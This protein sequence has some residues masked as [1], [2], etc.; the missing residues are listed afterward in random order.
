[1]NDFTLGYLGLS[2]ASWRTPEIEALAQS[3]LASLKTLPATVIHGGGLATTEE[4]AIARCRDFTRRGVD[5]V[6]LHFATF[7]LGAMIP[8]AAQRLHVPIVLFANP[9]EPGPGGAWSQNSFC[10]ANMAAYVLRNLGKPYHFAWGRA[11]RA[12]EA[13]R[14][15]VELRRCLAGLAETRLGWVG[16]RVPGFYTSSFDELKLRAAFGVAVESID[17]LEL[18][19]LA[20]TL[21]EAEAAEGLAGVRAGAAGTREVGEADLRLAASL[22]QAFRRLA[23]RYRLDGFAVRCWPELSDLYGI[24][25]CSV[26]GLLN[27]AGFVASCEGDVRG[28]VLMAILKRLGGATPFF[29]DLISFDESANAGVVWHCGAAPPSLCRRF[30]ETVLRLHG[31]VDGGDKKGVT[32]DFSLK[33]GRVTLAQLDETPSGYRMLIAPGTALD[34]EPFLRGNPL[35]IAF[36]GRVNTL[37]EA[38]MKRGLAHHYAVVHADLK[39]AL[40][41]VCE[42]KGIEPMTIG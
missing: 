6:V 29:V 1:M 22:F 40:Q 37:I 33:P 39:D 32:A 15:W 4:E 19:N 41:A 10:G 18:V 38:I 16:G 35:R 11:D 27:D 23:A 12:A 25:P 14:P 20:R 36:D 42:A 31:R 17:L 3:A 26:I 30:E 5:L 2:K 8:A 34:T 9:E 28:A 7:P 13:V 21:P 24:A